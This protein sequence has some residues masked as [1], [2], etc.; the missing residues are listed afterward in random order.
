MHFHIEIMFILKTIKSHFKGSYDKQNLTLMVI[1]YEIYETCQRLL[2][3]VVISYEIYEISYEMT[4][5]VRSS[6]FK[7]PSF[8]VCHSSSLSASIGASPELNHM[9]IKVVSHYNVG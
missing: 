6:I 3:Q 4:T 9:Q 7:I 8:A 1:L 2:T 5:C